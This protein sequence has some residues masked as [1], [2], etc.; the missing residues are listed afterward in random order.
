MTDNQPLANSIAARWDEH[1]DDLQSGRSRFL[2]LPWPSMEQIIRLGYRRKVGLVAQ[3]GRPEAVA[4]RRIAVHI[5][6]QVGHVLLCTAYPPSTHERLHIL[7]ERQLTPD[8]VNA[9]VRRLIKAG[10]APVL[11][12]IER[13][14]RMRF[15][16]PAEDTS[17]GD[18]LMWCGRN[19]DGQYEDLNIPAVFTTVV[20]QEPVMDK[21]IRAW[22]GADSPA[23]V[24]TDFC[25]TVLLVHRIGDDQVRVRVELDSDE[26]QHPLVK[27]V[28]WPHR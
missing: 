24:M 13:Y 8:M 20:D 18:E 7:E 19:V 15:A 25:R 16:E 10:T 26:Y 27:D 11:I 14:E 12:V 6:E 3:R 21:W 23:N 2:P 1:L 9:E 28:A 4:G 17:R 5:A 22:A